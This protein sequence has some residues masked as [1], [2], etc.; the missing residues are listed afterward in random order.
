[1]RSRG[2]K[3]RNPAFRRFA[4]KC[5][6]RWRIRRVWRP[7]RDRRRRPLSIS[8]K[9]FVTLE[10]LINC[11]SVAATRQV[12]HHPESGTNPGV[13]GTNQ[14]PDGTKT[15][16]SGTKIVLCGTPLEQ[17]RWP[18]SATVAD[19]S[20]SSALTCVTPRHFGTPEIDSQNCG[21]TRSLRNGRRRPCRTWRLR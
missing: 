17:R 9:S 1:M 21:V 4:P 14:R 12:F 18:R 8:R 16:V 15:G 2:R 13:N 6:W 3:S 10:K 5:L 7:W 19:R 11:C 20:R